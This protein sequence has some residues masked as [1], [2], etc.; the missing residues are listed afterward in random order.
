NGLKEAQP[1]LTVEQAKELS[2]QILNRIILIRVLET[3]GLQPYYSLVHQYMEWS[4]RVRNHERFPFFDTELMQT[5]DDIEMDLNTD[6]FKH[7]LMDRV[8]ATL[9]DAD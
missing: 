3:H 9:T 6:L 8:R 5:F 4:K 7:T 1:R 2:Q